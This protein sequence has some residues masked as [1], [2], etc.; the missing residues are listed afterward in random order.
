MEKT[1][2]KSQCSPILSQLNYSEMD[3]SDVVFRILLRLL[4]REI[5]KDDDPRKPE[6]NLLLLVLL[7]ILGFAG[8]ET[9]KVIFR[10]NFGANG[11]DTLKLGVCFIVFMILAA[12]STYLGYGNVEVETPLSYKVT[13]VFHFVFGLLIIEEGLKM[14]KQAQGA[15]EIPRSYQG[16]SHLLAFLMENKWWSQKRVQTIAEPLTV[17]TAGVLLSAFN[18]LL[19]LPFVF[20]AISVWIA[21]LFGIFTTSEVKN[22]LHAKGYGKQGDEFTKPNH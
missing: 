9:V 5:A 14:K 12:I 6:D 18:L 1:A 20:C 2:S 13:G 21:P 8:V 4:G 19:G 16:D 3:T 22:T 7:G 10:R 11:L 15:S 17:L